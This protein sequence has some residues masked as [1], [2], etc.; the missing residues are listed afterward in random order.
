MKHIYYADFSDLLREYREPKTNE[1]KIIKA[2]LNTIVDIIE[3]CIEGEGLFADEI[4]LNFSH[5]IALIKNL[6][7]KS[8]IEL[9]QKCENL[10]A[11]SGRSQL[12]YMPQAQG[13][14]ESQ[15]EYDYEVLDSFYNHFAKEGQLPYWQIETFQFE[16]DEQR[17][18]LVNLTLWDY[19][20]RI[21]TFANKYLFEI[22]PENIIPKIIHGE[23]A[24]EYE[25]YEPVVF[26]YNNLEMILAKFKVG[27]GKGSKQRL[28]IRSALRKL[29]EFKQ[30]ESNMNR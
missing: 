2:K 23:D 3:N 26:I 24:D 10:Q 18:K 6:Y 20:N 9:T 11:R 30:N 28:N 5:I 4:T 16:N 27:E 21:K 17:K 22:Y 19:C 13:I 1:D 8:I 29:N 14:T 15:F 25:S 12:A 7:Q